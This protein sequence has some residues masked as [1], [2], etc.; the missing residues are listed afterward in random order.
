MVPT[1]FYLVVW[2]QYDD[3]I[4][5]SPNWYQDLRNKMPLWKSMDPVEGR[6]IATTA[7]LP[8]WVGFVE[9]R[10]DTSMTAWD[11]V[12]V[13]DDLSFCMTQTLAEECG[14]ETRNVP[15]SYN[16]KRVSNQVFN[17]LL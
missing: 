6:N 7:M 2:H 1:I 9:D 16:F 11:A 13:I 3:T 8:R 15:L 12:K 10:G 17:F 4:F 5:P 14:R